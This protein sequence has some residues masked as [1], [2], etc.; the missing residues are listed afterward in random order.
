MNSPETSEILR[1]KNQ[2]QGEFSLHWFPGILEKNKFKII[3][4]DYYNLYL[5]NC[6]IKCLDRSKIYRGLLCYAIWSTFPLLV[7]WPVDRDFFRD[8]Q[9]LNFLTIWHSSMSDQLLRQRYNALLNSIHGTWAFQAWWSSPI[10]FSPYC[11]TTN[12]LTDKTVHI[13][14]GIQ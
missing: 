2:L 13:F 8:S 4:R 6:Y 14:P 1:I 9:F 7:A 10:R 5:K 11:T 3:E 12:F